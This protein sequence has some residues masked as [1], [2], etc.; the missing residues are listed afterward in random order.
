M[1]LKNVVR[2]NHEWVVELRRYFHANPEPSGKEYKTQKRIIAE[3]THMGLKPNVTAETGVFVDIQGGKPGKTV[4]IRADIDALELTDTCGKPYQSLNTGVCHGCGHDGHTAILLGVARGLTQIRESLSGKFRL[5]FQPSEEVF[6][7]GAIKMVEEGVLNDVYAI[8]ALHLW[9]PLEVGTIGVPYG[10]VM[11]APD[12]FKIN[13]SGRGGHGG[14]PHQAIDALLTGA[15]LVT[16]LNTV[17]SRNIDPLE[18]AALSI[19]VFRSGDMPNIVADT[20]V[21]QGTVRTFNE[22][23]RE[24]VFT[25]IEEISQGICQAAGAKF[26]LSKTLGFPPVVNEKKL[27]DI[28]V[29]TAGEVVGNNNIVD[30]KPLMVAEDFSVY[31]K[32]IPGV[33]MFVGSGN[34]KKGIVYPHHHPK[35]DIDEAAL[36]I[37]VELLIRTALKLLQ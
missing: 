27:A 26:S 11:A 22:G 32:K 12:E 18:N 21:I 17:I 30:M 7:G 14:M 3:L 25:R 10:P 34:A 16:A 5:I 31:Q 9:Q 29:K 4:A 35:Y 13:I 36:S 15:Q 6:P 37:G 1:E 33:Y 2:N 19:G 28:A 20:A 24:K 23:T 8:T